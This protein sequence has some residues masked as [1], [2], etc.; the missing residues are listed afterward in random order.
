MDSL[1]DDSDSSKGIIAMEK[2]VATI[3]ATLELE[4]EEAITKIMCIALECGA[5]IAAA[6]ETNKNK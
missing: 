1:M 4:L 3:Q 2:E 6:K 5:K